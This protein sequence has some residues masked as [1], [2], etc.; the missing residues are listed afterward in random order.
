ML[1]CCGVIYLCVCACVCACLCVL[2]CVCVCVCVCEC[3][4]VCAR[5]CVYYSVCVCV[6]VCVRVCV[7]YSVCVCVCVRACVRARASLPSLSLSHLVLCVL[8]VAVQYYSRTCKIIPTSQYYIFAANVRRSKELLHNVWKSAGSV[9][10]RTH[11]SAVT[12]I[13]LPQQGHPFT[14]AIDE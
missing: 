9:T 12:D 14:S 13:P 4:C 10:V 5:V 3:V 7:Y 11:S 8:C 1:E 2:L 6:R